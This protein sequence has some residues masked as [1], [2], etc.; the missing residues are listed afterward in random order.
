MT[1]PHRIA[2]RIPVLE[3]LR[4]GRR[5]ARRLYL[6]RDAKGLD[7]LRH[8]ARGI[9]IEEH[10]R[11]RLDQL[12]GT[13]M[14]QGAVLEAEPLPVWTPEDWLDTPLPDNALAVVLDGIVD[15]QNFGAIVRSAVAFGASGILFAQ[16]RSAPISTVAVKSAAGAME[17]ANLICAPNLVRA[18]KQLKDAGFWIAGLDLEGAVSLWDT[19]LAGR[20]ALVIGSE[21]KGMRRLVRDTCD[22]RLKIPMDGPVGVL[23]AS[24]SAAVALAECAR[25]RCARHARQEQAAP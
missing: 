10:D 8:A 16:D 21:G 18:M 2:G 3:C 7:S 6:L 17:Y 23:N 24:A 14:H 19:D 1:K 4:A 12:A 9:P 20:T 11:R 13:D 25:Q 15:P 5:A 22:Y